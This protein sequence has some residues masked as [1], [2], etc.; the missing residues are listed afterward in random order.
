MAASAEVPVR[1]VDR[2]TLPR[3]G[4]DAWVARMHRE[5][6]PSA[7]ARGYVLEGVWQ[8]RAADPGVFDGVDVVVEWR[9]PGVREFFR[10]RAGSHAPATVAWWAATDELALARSRSVLGP[11]G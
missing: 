10:A 7:E 9:L 4:A 11:Q 8:T 1:I 3:G 2:V 6:R 5:Y